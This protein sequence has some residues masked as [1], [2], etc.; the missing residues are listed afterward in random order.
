MNLEC[1]VVMTANRNVYDEPNGTKTGEMCR[2]GEDFGILYYKVD[3]NFNVWGY[4]MSGA[5]FVKLS[6]A[7]EV[8]E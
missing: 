4:L 5:G 7:C 3:E 6:G 2:K 1:R 8:M